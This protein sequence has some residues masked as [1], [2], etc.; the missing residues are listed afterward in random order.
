[1]R[2]IDMHCDTIYALLREGS[3]DLKENGLCVN[4]GNMKKA[5]SMAQ[6]FA[7]F[8]HAKDYDYNY[9][10]AYAKALEMIAYAKAE[11]TKQ[12]ENLKLALSAK[13]LTKNEKTGKISA[14]LTIEEGGILAG[15]LNRLERLYQEGIRLITLTWNFENCIGFSNK[16]GGGLKP[17]GIETVR[18][19]NE[20]GMLIDVSHL[21]DEGFWD[22][23]TYSKKPIVASHSNAR[24]LCEH[25]RNLSDDQLKALAENG[26]VAGINLFPYFVKESGNITAEDIAK[27]VAHMYRVGGEDV[28][29]IGTDFDG[30]DD[31]KSEIQHL[32]QIDVVYDAIKKQGFT[33]RQMEKIWYQNAMRVIHGSMFDGSNG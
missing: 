20:L 17:F 33:E 3:G 2:L 31:G 16:T 10:I 25:T 19:M 8:L 6:F 28:I 24:E 9:D 29:A 4:I 26:G 7:C 5:E 32:G 15:N 18:R 22:V 12:S 13:D 23:I 14:F 21:S 11:F 1:M 30:F 27:H